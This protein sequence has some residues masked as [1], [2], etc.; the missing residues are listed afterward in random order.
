ME[1]VD[2]KNVWQ[3]N[4]NKFSSQIQEQLTERASGDRNQF[5]TEQID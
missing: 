1:V 2:P 4:P 5:V 3:G